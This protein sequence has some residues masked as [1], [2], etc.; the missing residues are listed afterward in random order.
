MAGLLAQLFGT[1]IVSILL[2]ATSAIGIQKYNEDKQAGMNKNFLIFT[3]VFGILGVL[4]S[5]GLGGLKIRGQ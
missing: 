4:A 3:L 1:L 5:F 2:I